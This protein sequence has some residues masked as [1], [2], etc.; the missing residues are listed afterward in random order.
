MSKYYLE[1]DSCFDSD[2]QLKLKDLQTLRHYHSF[3]MPNWNS[4]EDIIFETGL[5]A[6]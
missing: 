6:I 2:I 1:N 4:P 5:I 3:I